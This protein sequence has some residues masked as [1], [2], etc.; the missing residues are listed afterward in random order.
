MEREGEGRRKMGRGGK[1]K[2][3]EER[4]GVNFWMVVKAHVGTVVLL[5]VYMY[6]Y[7]S[8]LVVLWLR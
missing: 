3:R 2:K 5:C 8:A 6:M 7:M 1:G 4:G